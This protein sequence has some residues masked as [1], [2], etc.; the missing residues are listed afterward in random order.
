MMDTLERR[1]ALVLVQ[2][3]FKV[4]RSFVSESAVDPLTVIVTL[5]VLEEIS[6]AFSSAGVAA[7]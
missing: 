6:G 3:V 2:L 7:R 1:G 5:N 4:H